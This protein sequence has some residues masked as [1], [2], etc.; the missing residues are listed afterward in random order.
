MGRERV[1]G[2]E[3]WRRVVGGVKDGGVVGGGKDGR[4]MVGRDWWLRWWR[5]G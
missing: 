1:V 4:W 2:M 3:E 5:S